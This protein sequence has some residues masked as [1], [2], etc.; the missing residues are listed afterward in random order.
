MRLLVVHRFGHRIGGVE[1]HL[2]DLVPALVRRGHEVLFVHGES[3]PAG[4]EPVVDP[5]HPHL[6]L[7]AEGVGTVLARVR[8]FDPALVYAHGLLPGPVMDTLLDRWPALWFAHAYEGACI[9]GSRCW[10]RPVPRPC[11]RPFGWGCLAQYLFRGCGGRSPSTMVRLFFQQRASLSRLRRFDRLATHSEAVRSEYLRLGIDAARIRVV[12]FPVRA[13]GR[14][15][16]QAPS[17]TG[18]E[19]LRLLYLG[20]FD[21]LKG[22]ALLLEAVPEIQRVLGRPVQLTLAGEGPERP[23]WQRLASQVESR[24]PGSEVRFPGWL[25][26]EARRAALAEAE[27]LVVP[28][29][30]PEPFGMTGLE[31]AGLGVPAVAFDV[32][33]IRAW[34]EPGRS[35]ELAPGDPPTVNGLVEAVVRAVRDPAH[36]QSLGAGA[37][38]QAERFGMEPHLAALEA[39]LNEAIAARRPVGVRG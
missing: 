23:S 31:A 22:G 14:G 24:A 34:L 26:G 28:S 9:S 17:K 13:L 32:G 18:G 38:A 2:Q 15:P 5:E 3:I 29:L 7:E 27:V 1:I 8:Q 33:G 12:P 11:P 10:Q 35:G 36:Y 30:W 4:H 25:G 6:D 21:P 39:L 37:R 16:V 19:A 20:R